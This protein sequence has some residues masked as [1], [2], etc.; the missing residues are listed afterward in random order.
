VRNWKP[1]WLGEDHAVK[2]I[3]RLYS[4]STS[5]SA[6]SVFERRSVVR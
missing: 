4:A 2:G 6:A 3:R 1:F 5:A